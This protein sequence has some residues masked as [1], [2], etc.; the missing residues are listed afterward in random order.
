MK[1]K[2]IDFNSYP[3]IEVPDISNFKRIKMFNNDA[4]SNRENNE[5]GVNEINA[6]EVEE[7]EQNNFNISNE[8]GNISE[9]DIIEDN[10]FG[11]PQN[12]NLGCIYKFFTCN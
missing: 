2:K 6:Q 3:V 12:L 10:N 9:N 8:I 11:L 7:N 5:I 1:E 4:P